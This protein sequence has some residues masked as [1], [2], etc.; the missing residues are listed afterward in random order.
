MGKN[1]CKIE[2]KWCKFCKK[3]NNPGCTFTLGFRTDF[4][5]IH[6]CPKREQN[7]TVSF[8]ELL[9][10]VSFEGIMDEMYK[11]WPEETKNYLGYKRLYVN[12][13]TLKGKRSD[14]LIES[15]IIYFDGW[16]KDGNRIP[17]ETCCP[18]ASCVNFNN[19]KEGYALDFWDWS[20][21]VNMN[22]E[23]ETLKNM[24]PE[25]ICAGVFYEITF[26]GFTQEK[27]NKKWKELTDIIDEIKIK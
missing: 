5:T 19:P 12:L 2:G 13:L 17:N 21:V 15:K 23:K 25:T 27:V 4:K 20:E 3:G 11:Y 9:F 14:Y 16:D 22:I 6:K 24:K 26:N 8:R 10:N 1:F 18:D 7:E